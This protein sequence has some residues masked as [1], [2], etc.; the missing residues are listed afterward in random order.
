MKWDDRLKE[1]AANKFKTYDIIRLALDDSREDEL[2]QIAGDG[3]KVHRVS[4]KNAALS[5]RLNRQDNN[6]LAM[7]DKTIIK[8]IYT[9]IY[10][11]NDAQAGE[12]IELITG[13][14]FD[15]L[16]AEHE[17]A[18]Q[19]VETITNAL[20]NTST[21][22]PDKSATTAE[23]KAHPDNVG[24]VWINFRAAAAQGS[25]LPLMPG[26]SIQIRIENLNQIK[27][28]FEIANEKAFICYES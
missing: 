4:S 22:G 7:N 9:H 28:N 25:C 10:I 1:Q 21:S 12:W 3:L 8:G 13:L 11:T 19:T 26:E 23:I 17:P 15:Y 27:A 20:A 14:D 18:A 5:I 6:A 2:I 16:E 24:K